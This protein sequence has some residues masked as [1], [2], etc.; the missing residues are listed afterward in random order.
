MVRVSVLGSTGYTGGEL[1]RILVG[2]PQVEIAALTSEQYAG[3]PYEQVYPALKGRLGRTCEAMDLERV[4]KRSD[5]VFTAVPH[6]KAMACV[7]HLLEQGKQVVDLSADFRLR[8]KAVYEAWYSP[9]T[10][11]ELLPQAVYGLPELHR[12]QI[13]GARLV[14]NPGCYPTSAILGAA[15]LIRLGW[16]NPHSLIVNSA[17]GVTGAG[18]SLALGSLYCEVNEG[19]KAY[20][21]ADHRHTPEIEQEVSLLAGLP[22]K[23]TFTPHLIP[24]SRGILSTLYLDLKE[25]RSD[26][27]VLGAYQA[28][29]GEEPFVR[30]LPMGTLP[31]VRDVRGTNYCDIG[32]KVDSRTRRVVVLSAIDNLTKGASGQAVQNMNLALGLPET[33]GLE[34]PPLFI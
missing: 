6:T 12:E 7:P 9:H 20:K 1:V 25:E 32:L 3:L 34:A 5:V 15:P 16:V 21:V 11:P 18:R 8:E 30:V 22:V 2:H 31:N 23:V 24:V 29:Y 27:E 14:A 19:M 28:F 26:A 33:L 10:A 13:R 4:A 17:S